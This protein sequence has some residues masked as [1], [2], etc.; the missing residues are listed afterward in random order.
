MNLLVRFV[1]RHGWAQ[2][3]LAA[4]AA[5]AVWSRPYLS[6]VLWFLGVFYGCF[7]WL[8]L[9]AGWW[10]GVGVCGG[11]LAGSWWAV[12]RMQAA[13]LGL[14]QLVA[15]WRTGGGAR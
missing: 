1:M 11:A 3:A 6:G 9:L 10:P 13:A 5:F 8:F 15:E 7:A 2:T 12:R 4:V 14:E